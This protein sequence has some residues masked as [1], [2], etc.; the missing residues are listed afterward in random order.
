VTIRTDWPA[1]VY[2][3]V[4]SNALY[5]GYPTIEK[6]WFAGPLDYAR[7]VISLCSNWAREIPQ[8]DGNGRP[9]PA[10]RP[11]TPAGC[12]GMERP[13]RRGSGDYGNGAT[14][15]AMAGTGQGQGQG[16]GKG[17]ARTPWRRAGPG[18]AGHLRPF[19]QGPG[20]ERDMKD[21][22]NGLRMRKWFTDAAYWNP[23]I[24][25]AGCAT[26]QVRLPDN[27]RTWR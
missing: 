2:L 24:M 14:S 6:D 15:R 19:A 4:V 12:P 22:L 3:A 13:L 9:W 20:H 8:D 11:A 5:Y 26:L 1:M 18:G 27:V 25:V 23:G 17:K 10:I 16:Q 7:S 21:D